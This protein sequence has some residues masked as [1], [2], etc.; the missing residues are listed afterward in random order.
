[1]KWVPKELIPKETLI[2]FRNNKNYSELR[3]CN[4]EK[5]QYYSCEVKCKTRGVII[6]ASNCGLVLGWREIYG[7]ESCT[8]VALFY[9]NLANLYVGNKFK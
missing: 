3:S 2:L 7:A 9:L 8:Q 1:M 6:A 4:T 5:S